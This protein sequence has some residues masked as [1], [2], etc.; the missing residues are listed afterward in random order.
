MNATEAK[1]RFSSLCARA[2]RTS[3]KKAF[4]VEPGEGMAV[5]D[6]GA[7]KRSACLVPVSPVVRPDGPVRRCCH[8]GQDGVTPAALAFGRA[9]VARVL[10]ADAAVLCTRRLARDLT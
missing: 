8:L 2:K 7:L 6:A 5:Q 4:E 9:G 3:C 10:P 1:N